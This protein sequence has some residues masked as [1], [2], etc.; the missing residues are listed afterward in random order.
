MVIVVSILIP[1][2]LNPDPSALENSTARSKAI[3]LAEAIQA[4]KA[5]KEA[6]QLEFEALQQSQLDRGE[7]G[8]HESEEDS[9]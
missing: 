8:I 5:P 7:L 6:W 9:E 4:E 2:R 3:A 1:A